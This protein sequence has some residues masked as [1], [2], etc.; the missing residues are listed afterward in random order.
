MGTLQN[1]KTGD[2][3]NRG[4]G[5]RDGTGEDF[6]ENRGLFVYLDVNTQ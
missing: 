5:T 6:L 4:D 2:E 3:T 1:P